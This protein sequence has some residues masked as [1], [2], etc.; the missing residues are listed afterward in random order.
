MEPVGGLVVADRSGNHMPYVPRHQ[1]SM[2]A[3]YNHPAGFMARVQADSWGEYYMDNANSEK[4]QG[5]DFVTNLMLGYEKGPHL[6]SLNVDNLFDK[7]YAT[8]VKKAGT[9]YSYPMS[10]KVIMSAGLWMISARG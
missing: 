1:F 7:H 10:A 6:V 9:R 8:E 3:E 4:Y 5:Y 2:N